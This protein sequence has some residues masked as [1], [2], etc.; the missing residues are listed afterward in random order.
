MKLA[1]H[2]QLDA[3]IGE[4]VLG[5]L[6]GS[7]RR[8][9]ERA[10]REEPAVAL[11]LR[12]LQRDFA[13][14]YSERI[15]EAPA[16]GGWSRL[17]RELNLLRYRA[18]WHSRA[19]FLRAWAFGATAALLLSAVLLVLRTTTETTLAPI[20][21]LAMKGASPSVTAHLSADGRTLVLHADRPVV[22]GPLQS[23]ELWLIPAEVGAPLSLAVL[24]QLEATLQMP[25]GHVGRLRKGAQLAVS[26]EPAGGSPSGAPTGPVILHGAIGT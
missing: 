14:R 15:A 5:S 17:Q 13:P 22:A 12:T 11:R 6:R 24:G 20:A 25:A 19:S 9:F 7:A 21:H 18:P 2:P 3:L 10:L 4:Y 1:R 26:V 23:Y 16:A 8:R